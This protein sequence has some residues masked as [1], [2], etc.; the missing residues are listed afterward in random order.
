MPT[1]PR[2]ING[3]GCQMV[4]PVA[5]DENSSEIVWVMDCDYKVDGF[6]CILINLELFAGLD[7]SECVGYCHAYSSNPVH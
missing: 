2:A 6:N 5:D 7:A 1:F 3:P 4:K